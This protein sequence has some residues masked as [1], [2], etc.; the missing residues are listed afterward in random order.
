MTYM[1]WAGHDPALGACTDYVVEADIGELSPGHRLTVR[2]VC[3]D[4][5]GDRLWLFY[6]WTPGLTEPMGEDSGVW[7]NVENGADMPAA[8]GSS[9]GSYSTDGGEFSEGEIGY[10]LPPA[11]AR[12]LWFDFY[13]AADEDHRACRL[14][15]DLAVRQA[16]VGR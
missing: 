13:A 4:Q 1:P 8:D 6:A 16:S 5:D 14:P 2:G 10:A 15:I 3:L 7:L 11:S 12:H 9:A